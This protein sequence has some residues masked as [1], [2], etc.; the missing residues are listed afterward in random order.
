MSPPTRLAQYTADA[1]GCENIFHFGVAIQHLHLLF[2]AIAPLRS[3]V[4]DS[5]VCANVRYM[6][7]TYQCEV[8][9]HRSAMPGA[10]E[11]M[12]FW[13]AA[14]L[15]A[16][17]SHSHVGLP[18]RSTL[19]SRGRKKR[20]RSTLLTATQQLTYPATSSTNTLPKRYTVPALTPSP[21]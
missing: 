11:C 18:S 5:A 1:M 4:S 13:C 3:G 14:S 15:S 10:G 9:V 2:A 16:A 6:G 12:A 21:S 8:G 20:L 19:Y 7:T 17:C